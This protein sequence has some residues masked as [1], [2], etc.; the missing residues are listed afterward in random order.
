MTRFEEDLMTAKDDAFVGIVILKERKREL[1]ELSK[2][3]NCE[4][5]KF[6]MQ[7]IAQEYKKL[8]A[9]YDE[10]EKVI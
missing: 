3:G 9:Q 4:K 10:I 1:E 8:K 5:N 7:C 2:K 6:R